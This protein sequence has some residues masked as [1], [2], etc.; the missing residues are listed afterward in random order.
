MQTNFTRRPIGGFLPLELPFN[1]PAT[2][3]VWHHIT[4]G[5]AQIIQQQN[6]RAVFAALFYGLSP[7]T[8]WYPA[9]ICPE[10]VLSPFSN[11]IR[12][13]PVGY[14]LRPDFE[15]LEGRL[16]AR[17]AV[18][19]VDYF[20]SKRKEEWLRFSSHRSDILWIEDSAQALDP[21]SCWGDWVVYSPRKL[22]GIPDGGIG[23]CRNG[24]KQI[25][26]PVVSRPLTF[27]N[28]SARLAPL[29][30]R[31]EDKG[32]SRNKIW[33]SAYRKAEE[34]EISFQE[35]DLRWTMSRLS[36]DILNALDVRTAIA[37]RQQNA[38][39]LHKAVPEKL[40]FWQTL[41]NNPL[42]GYPIIS[43][44]RDEIASRL[45]ASVIF[46]PVHWRDIPAPQKDFPDEHRLS[47]KLLT[48]PCDQRYGTSEML[49]I[50]EALA[51]LADADPY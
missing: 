26:F 51:A 3:S 22:F 39:V 10:V 42:L 29:Y 33:Y 48:L 25:E 21:Q 49:Q 40:R 7:N 35:A 5:A 43:A 28:A 8:I 13:Y 6:A 19:G 9:Y 18:I 23:V 47:E 41:P 27:E 37:K 50:A 44:N 2:H 46:C 11:R 16:N 4:D 34:S 30:W 20:G 14:E 36:F 45:A 1:D 24:S 32:E 17:D 15:W 31:Y 38:E 12:F